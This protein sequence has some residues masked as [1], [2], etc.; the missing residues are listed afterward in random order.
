MITIKLKL[1]LLYD[2]EIPFLDI[3][4]KETKS[5]SCKYVYIVM[6]IPEM[7]NSGQMVLKKCGASTQ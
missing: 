6:F 3:C 1:E 2:P 4:K 7:F 5:T